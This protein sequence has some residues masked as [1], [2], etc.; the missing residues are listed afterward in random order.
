MKEVDTMNLI[1]GLGLIVIGILQ[2][3]TAR[4]MNNNIKK[5]VK[6]PQPYVFVG[7]YISL[8]IGIIL[9]VWGAWLLK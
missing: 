1:F 2:I 9:L 4:V 3:N 8:I 7:V 6:N 5:N